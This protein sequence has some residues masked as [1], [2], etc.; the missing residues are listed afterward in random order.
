[1]CPLSAF[2][3]FS[4]AFKI[5]GGAFFVTLHP[6]PFKKWLS[7]PTPTGI[8]NG[9]IRFR[10]ENRA[11][12]GPPIKMNMSPAPVIFGKAA[13]DAHLKAIVFKWMRNLRFLW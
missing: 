12:L 7:L 6:Y 4:F 8:V 13:Y 2:I 10:T 3:F 11:A 1:M 5:K 9:R